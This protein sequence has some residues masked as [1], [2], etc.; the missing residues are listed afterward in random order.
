MTITVALL[1]GAATF[2]FGVFP[3][4]VLGWVSPPDQP[5]LAALWYG[6]L[7][8][9]ALVAF[10]ISAIG[11]YF[12]SGLIAIPFNEL[13][14]E[15]VEAMHLGRLDEPFE[16]GLMASDIFRS[17]RHSIAALLL[18]GMIIIPL[19]LLNI[20]PVL[21]ELVYIAIWVPLT[22]FFLARELLD[23][24]LS[25]RRMSFGAK[26]RLLR[27]HL[28]LMLGLGCCAMVMLWVPL[29]NFVSLPAAIAGGTLLY[30]HM[31]AAGL[32]VD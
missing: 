5:T 2:A 31:Q 21:G 4:W 20:V 25:R 27:R 23:S 17:I 28:P 30:C 16:L 12:L 24:P 15:R 29:L 7:G 14:S 8:V 22:A 10:V 32:I 1:A 6:L 13:L 9:L 3:T 26:L 19:L 18:W 11:L